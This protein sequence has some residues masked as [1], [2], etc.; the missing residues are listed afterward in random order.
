MGGL[1]FQNGR[2]MNFS[3]STS[4]EQLQ[5][6]IFQSLTVKCYGK[7]TFNAEI[8]VQENIGLVNASVNGNKNKIIN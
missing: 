6:R 7:N 1:P 2:Y 5:E 4:S 8:N 3:S